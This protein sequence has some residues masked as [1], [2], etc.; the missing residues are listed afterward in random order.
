MSKK[1]KC[2][3]AIQNELLLASLSRFFSKRD[4]LKKILAIVNGTTSISL[5]LIDWFVTNYSKKCKTV[6]VKTSNREHIQVYVHYRSQLRAFSKQLFDPFR[7]QDKIAFYYDKQNFF[8]TT[9]GQL[10]FFRW[11]IENDIL[12][13]IKDNYDLI[14]KDMN[15]TQ[16]ENASIKSDHNAQQNAQDGGGSSSK[17]SADSITKFNPKTRGKSSLNNMSVMK[18]S[19]VISFD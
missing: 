18:G 8:H 19:C 10:N 11:A 1:G 6:I 2:S 17:V 15:Q 16:K 4:N 12:E 5:R 13:Y 3:S 14:V 9:I 7:R